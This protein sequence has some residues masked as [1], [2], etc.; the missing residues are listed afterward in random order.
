MAD[1][2]SAKPWL[3]FYDKH[4]PPN[5]AYPDKTYL[6]YFREAVESVPRKVAVYYMGRYMGRGITFHELDRLS[7]K[8]ARVAGI[9]NYYS[10][11]CEM[12]FPLR[13]PPSVFS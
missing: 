9:A 4:V 3:K 11:S 10:Q 1:P 8:F 13:P 12:I 2:Y 6:S 5:L 7:D